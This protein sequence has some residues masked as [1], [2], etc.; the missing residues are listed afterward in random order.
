M[1]PLHLSTLASLLF[2]TINLDAQD[3][4]TEPPLVAIPAFADR[5]GD[6]ATRV[7]PGTYR[8]KNVNVGNDTTR[9]ASTNEGKSLET[10][11]SRDVYEKQLERDIEFAPGDWKLPQQASLVAADA[12]TAAFKNS[13]KFRVLDRST[14]GLKLIDNERLF[15]ATS[16][17]DDSLIKVCREKNASFL[18]VGALTSFR[19]DT[20]EGVVYGV[21]RRSINTRVSMDIRVTDVASTEIV[22]Q[23]APTKDVKIQLPEGVTS[24][25]EVYD[26]EK[27]L[28][29]AVEEA[30]DEMIKKVAQG[31][32]VEAPSEPSTLISISTEPPGADIL[33]DGDFVGNTPAEIEVPSRRIQIQ[34]KRQGY[35]IWEN[36][37]MPKNEM[38]ISPALLPLPEPPSI[39]VESKDKP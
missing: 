25:T 3:K 8:E 4:S 35:Q 5:T 31:T 20:R 17:A 29:T 11:S 33:I 2:G 34:L 23:A 26:W 27:V 15:A 9:E 39:P 1:K 18:V 16:G 22:Y 36:Q 14:S 13:G 32:G 12:V 38:K 28:R 7:A 24:F 19:V 6:H 30:A 10:S 37:V 21:N